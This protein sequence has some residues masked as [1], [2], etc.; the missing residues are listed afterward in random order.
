VMFIIL[1][2]DLGPVKR[3]WKCVCGVFEDSAFISNYTYIPVC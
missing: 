2:S 1:L 3:Q